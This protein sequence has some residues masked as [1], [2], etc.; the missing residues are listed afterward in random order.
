[1]KPASNLNQKRLKRIAAIAF[2]F[3]ILS[4]LVF[5]GIFQ[6]QPGSSGLGEPSSLASKDHG[7]KDSTGKISVTASSSSSSSPSLSNA[8]IDSLDVENA[9][10]N[11]NV[12]E[13]YNLPSPDECTQIVKNLASMIPNEN[14]TSIA[15]STSM[16]MISSNDH[17]HNISTELVAPEVEVVGLK[18]QLKPLWLNMYPSTMTKSAFSQFFTLLTNRSDGAKSYY[19]IQGRMRKCLGG[20]QTVACENVHPTVG[21]ADPDGPAKFNNFFGK[22]ILT[23]RNPLHAMPASVYVKAQKYHDLVGPLPEESWIGTRD[24]WVEKMWDEWKSTITAWHDTKYEAGMYLAYEDIFD[25]KKGPKTLMKLALLLQEAGFEI[26][27]LGEDEGNNGNNGNGNG[28]GSG[29][30]NHTSIKSNYDESLDLENLYSY[31]K[32][33]RIHCLWS[34]LEIPKGGMHDFEDWGYT[35]SYT[36]DHKVMLKKGL[37]QLM[38][39][40]REHELNNTWTG[41]LDLIDILE[42]YRVDVS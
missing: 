4:L 24:A 3:I 21:M 1:V 12:N 35:P 9:N 30:G 11:M 13:E 32:E 2:V 15:T 29:N 6:S 18:E 33:E 42:R 31:S 8:N 37:D 25:S 7:Y 39:E 28:N 17:D 27:A 10:V 38:D 23:L 34:H 5:G 40:V 26:F 22:Y 19:A 20:S 41:G 36:E 14:P 16:G